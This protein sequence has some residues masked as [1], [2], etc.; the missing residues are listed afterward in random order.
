VRILKRAAAL[1]AVAALALPASAPGAEY[2]GKTAQGLKVSARVTDG[3]LKLLKITWRVPCDHAGPWKDRTYWEDR[4]EGPIEHDGT[5][6]TDGGVQERKFTDGR[7]TYN[8]KLSGEIA[9][10]RITGKMTVKMK[11]YS[12]D[13]EHVNNCRGTIR[14]NIPRV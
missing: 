11:L 12:T 3:R 13:G 2:R 6:F 14:F 9:D 5:R 7:V 1:A 10:K 4:P 8:L